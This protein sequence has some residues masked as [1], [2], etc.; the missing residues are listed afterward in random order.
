M[1]KDKEY[2]PSFWHKYIAALSENPEHEWLN[3]VAGAHLRTVKSTSRIVFYS[4]LVFFSL[5]LVWSTMFE[6]DEYV[7]AQGKI[8]PES[9]VKSLS[10]FEGGIV[11]N[12]FVKEGDKV[13]KD[14]VLIELSD[15]SSKAIYQESLQNYYNHW[16]QMLR[17]RAQINNTDLVLPTEIKE[18]SP[19]MVNETIERYHSSQAAYHNEEKI[20][21]EQ[22]TGYRSELAELTEKIRNLENLYKLSKERTDLL[23]KLVEQNLLSKT[24]YIASKMDTANRFMELES[25]QSNINKLEARIREGQGRLN[26][27]KLHYNTQDWQ[28]LK[29]HKIR[30]EEAKKMIVAGKDRV[31]RADIKSP[32]NGIVQQL[33]VHTIGAAVTSGR[34]L[35]SI[36]PIKDSLL[37]EA[38]VMPQDIGFIHVGDPATIKV[39]AYDYSIY[40]GI[41]GVVEKISPDA[42]EDPRDH[43][44]TYYRVHIR[45]EKNTIEHH[46]KVY[47]LIPGETV[48]ADIITGQRTIMQYLIKPIA[49][50]L[51]DPLRER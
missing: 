29:D 30:F 2:K 4:I 8:E 24:Q 23:T 36:V 22:L 34:E 33:F 25:A 50:S 26:Q 40:G 11:Q 10:H 13:K 16:A 32:V 9:E 14:Q 20:L 1:S 21:K 5:F 41:K 37:V 31:D 45:A 44:I 19:A 12:I 17:L 6:I 27:V 46:G 43:N 3:P 42:V 7:H 28:E 48:Q 18:Y 51:S 39:S 35:V 49:K 47:T 15:V 38:K